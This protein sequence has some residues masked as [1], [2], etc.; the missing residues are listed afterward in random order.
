MITYL[1]ALTLVASPISDQVENSITTFVQSHFAV[2]QAQYQYNFKRINYALF[3]QDLDSVS[4]MRIGKSSPVGN[5]VFSLGC[6]K[7]DKIVKTVSVSVEV[8]LIVDCLVANGPINVGGKFTDLVMTRRAITSDS[9][10]P[11]SDISQ[12]SGKQAKNY[13]QPGVPIY[14]SMCENIPL[15]NPGN[16][17]SIVVEH[18][19]IKVVAQGIAKQKG[20]VGDK[21]RVTNLGSNK[22]IIAEVIDSMTVALK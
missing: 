14:P 16:H 15:I 1:L 13:I 6:Y 5:T 18:G 7:A 22:M 2:N 11:I 4:V 3:P 12:L 9:Q 17:V 20:G 19:Q 10:L 21:I 8:S